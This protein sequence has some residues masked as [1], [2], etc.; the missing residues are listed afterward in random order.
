MVNNNLV[1]FSKGF[2][3]SKILSLVLIIGDEFS[4]PELKLF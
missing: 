4:C 1:A 2:R 3:T